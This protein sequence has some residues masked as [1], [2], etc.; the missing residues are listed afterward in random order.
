MRI[1]YF[2]GDMFYSCM[3]Q[4]LKTGHE[5][6]ALFT[7][8]PNENEYDST[9]NVCRQA[10][11]LGIPITRSKPTAEDISELQRNKCDMILVAGYSYKIPAWEGENIKYGIN[12]H[13]S[14]LPEGAGPMPLP[15][16]ITKGL[17]RTGVTLHKLSQEWDAGD[18]VLQESFPLF[19]NENLEGLL[20]DSQKLAVR[21][22]ERFLE[23]PKQFWDNASPQTRQ[24]G[25]YW[26][27]PTSED[28]TADFGQD[29]KTV[30]RYLR[31]F[32]V[33]DLEG[34]VAFVSSVYSWQHKHGLAPGTI[35]SKKDNG[36][37]ATAADGFVCFK[38]EIKSSQNGDVAS[39]TPIEKLAKNS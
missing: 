21:L 6:I 22:L 4:L 33:I 38:L 17:K 16:V 30:S 3:E 5:I 7:V 36:C 34:N 14:L 1:A 8:A 11:A 35:L 31:T 15:F 18:I 39:E 23:S 32:R 9:Q 37:L 28:L 19:G 25:N 2:G 20:C 27:M 12:I 13:P 24:E 10:E 26:P 29:V